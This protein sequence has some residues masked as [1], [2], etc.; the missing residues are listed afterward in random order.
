MSVKKYF[1]DENNAV[2]L[3]IDVQE[4]LV[5]AMPKKELVIKNSLHLIELA[6]MMNIPI[7]V[8][9]QYPKGLGK[10]VS[11]IQSALPQYQ[12]IEKKT[13]CCC[14]EPEFQHRLQTLSGRTLIVAGM[15][16]HIC[17]LQTVLSL[18]D[19]G[20][21]THVVQ[22]AACSRSEENEKTGIEFMRD[23]GAVITCTE[24][25]LFQFLKTAGTE[26]FK[27]ISQRIK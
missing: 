17:V 25:V 21:V 23:A 18:L 16:T 12:P 22:D 4:R 27:K 11:E 9:E 13:F 26:A 3:I 8:T 15:E 5:P 1:L 7:I 19:Q 10:T 14:R 6:T 24:T 20:L 2:L